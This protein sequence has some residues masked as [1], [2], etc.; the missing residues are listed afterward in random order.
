MSVMIMGEDVRVATAKNMLLMGLKGKVVLET[1]RTVTIK[2]DAG[3]KL[4]LPKKGTAFELLSSGR[5]VI[6]DE[7]EGRPEERIAGVV[8][9]RR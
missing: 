6:G 4:M 9:R 3:R 2:T 1:M 5:V 8:K 7:I